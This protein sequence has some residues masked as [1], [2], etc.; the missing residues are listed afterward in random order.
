MR[1]ADAVDNSARASALAP[2]GHSDTT[3]LRAA[4]RSVKTDVAPREMGACRFPGPM[5][6]RSLAVRAT[7]RLVCAA[8]LSSVWKRP[9]GDEHAGGVQEGAI[10]FELVLVP[11]DET[12]EVMQPRV[13]A[14]DDPAALE[15]CPALAAVLVLGPRCCGAASALAG[16]GRREGWLHERASLPRGGSRRAWQA[17]G[18]L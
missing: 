18:A 17:K 14:L 8:A 2:R 12:T 6:R 1:E 5:T 4:L 16:P 7:A 3:N 9:E 11:G 15:P 13:G 10:V